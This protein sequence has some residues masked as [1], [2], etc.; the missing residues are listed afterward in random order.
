FR[1]IQSG[2]NFSSVDDSVTVAA[3]TY[4]ENIN[5]RGRNIKVAGADRETTI[6]DG[7]STGTVV[8]FESGEDSTA[9]LS[10][11]TIQNGYSI[12]GGGIHYSG[13]NATLDNLTIINNTSSNDGGGIYSVS[14]SMTISN[15][16]INGN[17]ALNEGGAIRISETSFLEMSNSIVENNQSGSEMDGLY[18]SGSSVSITNSVFKSN[19]YIGITLGGNG[20]R[21]NLISKTL[22]HGHSMGIMSSGG[23]LTVD[24][25]T[26]DNNSG[27]GINFSYG[28][29]RSITNSIIYNNGFTEFGYNLY[30]GGAEDAV[31]SIS[32]SDIQ[33]DSVFVTEGNLTWGNGN[34]DVDPMFVD[35]ADGN[36]HL[37]ATSQCINAGHPDS[38]DSDGTVAD[39]GAYPYLNS[40]SGPTWYISE[41]GN[42][43][44]ATGASGDPFRSIQS[45]I[46]FSSVDDSV[47]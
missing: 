40:Y 5:F 33:G 31:L 20:P 2:I 47:T 30:M 15:S 11:F 26:I 8:T 17:T 34:I 22:V 6:I 39:I 37:L 46:N 42:D 21:E 12:W 4:V 35:T 18:S 7:D 36:Y 14:S 19:G 45:G 41:S 43:T 13:S 1:S 25:S 28:G 9:L 44:T 27:H 23:D 29:T 3:G 16:T 10:G 24:K 38:T 32:Y